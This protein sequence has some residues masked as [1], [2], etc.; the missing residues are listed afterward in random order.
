MKAL[1]IVVQLL[2]SLSTLCHSQEQQQA[3]TSEHIESLATS[4]AKSKAIDD[5]HK[6]GVS[7]FPGLLSHFN[8]ERFCMEEDKMSAPPWDRTKYQR[9]VGFVC[10][11][12]VER[13]IRHYVRWEDEPDPRFFPGYSTTFIPFEDEAIKAW[14]ERNKNKE[15]WELQSDFIDLV[16]EENRKR[17]SALAQGAIRDKCLRAIEKN[18]ELAASIRSEKKSLESK[19]FR[20]YRD[21]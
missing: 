4:K 10:R 6:L 21:R 20:P 13:Q 16:V 7:A 3:T 18:V 1:V 2:F 19:P 9:S 11:Q 17:L 8:D 15:L 5:L 14:W 12:I